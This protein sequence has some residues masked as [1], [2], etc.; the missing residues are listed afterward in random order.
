MGDLAK[1]SSSGP[2]E[3]RLAVNLPFKAVRFYQGVR[4]GTW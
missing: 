4:R 2:E 3:L 1:F